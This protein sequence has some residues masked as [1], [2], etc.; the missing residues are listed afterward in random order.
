MPTF[1]PEG[2]HSVTPRLVV[3]DPAGLVAFLKAAFDATGDLPAGAP[4]VMRIGDSNVMVSRAG[5]RDAITALLYVYIEDVEATY[6]RALD[7]GGVSIEEPVDVPYGDR[8]AMIEDPG[9]NIWQ[10]ATYKGAAELQP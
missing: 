8:R 5:P 2:W 7:A 4:A 1:V 10:I 3:E 9:G 6:R